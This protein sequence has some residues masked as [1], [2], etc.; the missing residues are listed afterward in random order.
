MNWSAWR[1]NTSDWPIGRNTSG[2]ISKAVVAEIA[3]LL[4]LFFGKRVLRLPAYERIGQWGSENLKTARYGLI[5]LPEML[6]LLVFQAA[7]NAKNVKWILGHKG[8]AF[9]LSVTAPADRPVK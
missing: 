6:G 8:C 4:F 9:G 3:R 7:R 1:S 5:H 2:R